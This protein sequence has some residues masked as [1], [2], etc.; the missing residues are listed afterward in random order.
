M[1]FWKDIC[2]RKPYGIYFVELEE[3]KDQHFAYRRYPATVEYTSDHAISFH[4]QSTKDAVST[5]SADHSLASSSAPSDRKSNEE[6]SS[7][8]AGEMDA[9][10]PEIPEEDEGLDPFFSS[11]QS[12]KTQLPQP[13]P[14]K[15]YC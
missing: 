2:F 1:Y 8:L 3:P 6:I 10:L 15:F 13:D 4:Y 11:F 14:S 12:P 9:M 7:T 5:S